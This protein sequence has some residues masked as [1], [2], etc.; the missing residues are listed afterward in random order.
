[1]V[2]PFGCRRVRG[3]QVRYRR[4]R[5]HA[6]VEAYPNSRVSNRDLVGSDSHR[7]GGL[8]HSGDE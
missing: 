3:S 5:H 7:S 2:D 6:A 8:L 1:M 4:I